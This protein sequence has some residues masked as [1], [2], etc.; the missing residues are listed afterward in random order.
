MSSGLQMKF[1]AV[2]S[3]PVPFGQASDAKIAE[4]VTEFALANDIADENDTGQVMADKFAEWAAGYLA[5]HIRAWKVAQKRTEGEIAARAAGAALF[6][7]GGKIDGRRIGIDQPRPR[8][9]GRETTAG[10][11]AV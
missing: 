10:S 1:G 7:Q 8:T 11:A 4:V 6:D 2:T 3:Q 9:I 5:A